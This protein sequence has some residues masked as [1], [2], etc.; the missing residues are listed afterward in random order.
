MNDRPRGKWSD[1]GVPHNGWTCVDF[2]DLGELS[3]LCGMCE[4]QEIRYVHYMQHPQYS[5]LVGAGCDCAAKCPMT[6]TRHSKRERAVNG[7]P[8]AVVSAG[9][10]SWPET[11][12]PPPRGF[13]PQG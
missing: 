9:L 3:G 11:G 12:R 5:G 4:N 1:P 7:P 8:R 2:E 10:H 6:T 13:V